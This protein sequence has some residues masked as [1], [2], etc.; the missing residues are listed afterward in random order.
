MKI[1]KLFYAQ[2]AEK[3]G[4]LAV[5]IDVFR[6]FSTACY[7][8]GSGAGKVILAESADGAFHIKRENPESVLVGE[9]C[10]KIIP[11]FDCGN[12]PSA[13]RK[14]EISGRTA[15]LTTSAGTRG[16]LAAKKADEVVTGSFV[17]A[18]A[19]IEYILMKKPEELSL[20]CMGWNA[21]EPADEDNMCADYIKSVLEGVPA[22][23]RKISGYLRR[24]S[25][26]KSFLDLEGEKSAPEED[27]DLCLSLDAF[28]FVLRAAGGEL[29][30]IYPS[31]SSAAS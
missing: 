19:V 20:V 26:T 24:E 18:G 15:V 8:F 6:A 28:D 3:A 11:G 7:I 2:G 30:R 10:G 13:V 29:E 9:R 31:K 25:A 27:F 1:R 21:S 4:G 23:F 22:D 14:L 5:I 17:N 16:V 12:S